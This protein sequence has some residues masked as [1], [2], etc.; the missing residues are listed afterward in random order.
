[1]N[2]DTEIFASIRPALATTGGPLVIIST[3]Y[4]RRGETW[5]LFAQNFGPEG[6]PRILVARGARRDL[7]A[8]LAQL[9]V[10]RALERDPDSGKTFPLL[11]I[12]PP[13]S[14]ASSPTAW[15][16]RRCAAI[17]ISALSIRAAAVAT[18]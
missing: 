16:V 12:A 18:R 7:N 6:D 10:D 3:P 4:A 13:S 2:P 9:V 17:A 8:T 5:Q 1:M 15:N 11:L 14:A